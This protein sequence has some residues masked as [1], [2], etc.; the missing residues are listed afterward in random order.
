MPVA[1]A[2]F[3]THSFFTAA[4]SH[5]S[6]RRAFTTDPNRAASLVMYDGSRD[7]PSSPELNARQVLATME[8]WINTCARNLY[9]SWEA[10]Y[11]CEPQRELP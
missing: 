10:S 8:L 5:S 1:V 7:S 3:S 11:V 2:S 9:S 6:K 4:R